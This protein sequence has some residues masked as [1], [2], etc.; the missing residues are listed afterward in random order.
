VTTLREIYPDATDTQL[1]HMYRH[2]M[3]NAW[4]SEAPSEG[5]WGQTIFWGEHAVPAEWRARWYA[6]HPIDTYTKEHA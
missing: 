3:Q 2:E 4:I 1:Q 5:R 6:E